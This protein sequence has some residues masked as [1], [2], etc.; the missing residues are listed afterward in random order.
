M[1]DVVKKRR[2]SLAALLVTPPRQ[3]RAYLKGERQE[4]TQFAWRALEFGLK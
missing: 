1:E 4:L 3:L 2:R